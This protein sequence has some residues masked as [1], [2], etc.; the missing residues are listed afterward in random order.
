ML[1]YLIVGYGL[2]GLSFS[3]QL[4]NHNKSFVVISESHNSSSVVAGGM[5]NPV[6]LKRFTSPWNAL[7]QLEYAIPFY[8]EIEDRLAIK[9]L[10]P[11]AVLRVFNSIEEQNNWLI[12]S[13]KAN[14]TPFLSVDF[15][16]NTNVIN[17]IQI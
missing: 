16:A 13:D 4:R 17:T 3:T 14:L 2:A 8:Q 15:I 5:Y 11:M 10:S 12:S 9:V 6:I 7:A 1:D